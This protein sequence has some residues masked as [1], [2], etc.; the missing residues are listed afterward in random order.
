VIFLIIYLAVNKEK[1]DIILS[2]VG[3]VGVLISVW[4]ITL[5]MDKTRKLF[6]NQEEIINNLETKDTNDFPENLKDIGELVD[7]CEKNGYLLDIYTNA[8]GY[9]IFSNNRQ[10][11]IFY[12]KISKCE[13]IQIHWHYYGDT[14]LKEQ[15]KRQFAS[16]ENSQEKIDEKIKK[17]QEKVVRYCPNRLKKKCNLQESECRCKDDTKKQCRLILTIQT[18][19]KSVTDTV[20]NLSQIAIEQIESLE[21][22]KIVRRVFRFENDLPFCA[23]I[24]LKINRKTNKRE[25]IKGIFAYNTYINDID[26]GF[27]TSNPRLLT[28]LFT[29]LQAPVIAPFKEKTK[30]ILGKK[31]E[32][33]TDEDK[34]ELDALLTQYKKYANEEF[35]KE[36]KDFYDEFYRTQT[37]NI[38]KQ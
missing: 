8:P 24:A 9:G 21:K 33:I 16:W 19:Y 34:K 22:A 10:W 20:Y 18:N 4:A 26:K 31:K 27:K 3:A 7:E 38:Y 14:K 23:W 36:L 2:L 12:D 15:I 1:I 29:I 17:R 28:A 30:L 13:N 6:K 32:E 37:L 25:L 11:N 35:Y 5:S